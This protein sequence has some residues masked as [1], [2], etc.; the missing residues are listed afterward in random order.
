MSL[1]L[2]QENTILIFRRKSGKDAKLRSSE[3]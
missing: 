1:K 3:C 2:G